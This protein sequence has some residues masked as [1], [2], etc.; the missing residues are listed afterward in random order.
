MFGTHFCAVVTVS[1]GYVQGRIDVKYNMAACFE[2][3][4]L[5][6]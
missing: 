6:A 1:F 5:S 3:P 4:L 2:Q